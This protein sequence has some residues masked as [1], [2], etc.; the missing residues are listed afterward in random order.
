MLTILRHIIQEVSSTQDFN[1]AMDIMVK[2][3][4]N[5]LATEAC[6]V[7]L[8]DRRH[9]SYV[10]VATQGLNPEG[11]GKIRVPLNKGLIGLIGDREEPLNI[12]DATQHPR[13]FHVEEAKEEA[14]RAFLGAPI[15]YHRQVLGVM[16]VQ[17]REPRRY[18]EAEEAFLVTLATQLAA[19]ISHAEST[20]VLTDFLDGTNKVKHDK[21]YS[22]V[23]GAPGIGVGTG[24]IVYA[25]FD[26]DTVPDRT[27]ED[28]EHEI[29]L[30]H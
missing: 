19:H 21:I 29:E 14:F 4:A 17:Q 6:S 25:P 11:I 13:F 10:L 24:V 18:D 15:I 7:F 30:L 28:P 5:A 3:I 20:G 2:R 27:P 8:L 16:I 12:D 23:P 9:G 1:E 26:L 22:G